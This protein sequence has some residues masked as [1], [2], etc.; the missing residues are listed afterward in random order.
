MITR[1]NGG[2]GLVFT[3]GNWLYIC[4]NGPGSFFALEI[5]RLGRVLSFYFWDKMN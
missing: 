1:V 4:M 5:G 3:I 2:K